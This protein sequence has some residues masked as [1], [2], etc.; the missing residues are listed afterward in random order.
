MET[1]MMKITISFT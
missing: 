1:K